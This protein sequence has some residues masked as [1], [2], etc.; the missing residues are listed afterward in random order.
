M[1]EFTLSDNG[2]TARVEI[3]GGTCLLEVLSLQDAAYAVLP[4]EK[5]RF[6]SRQGM[7]YY[8]NL[9][10]RQGGVV[11]GVRVDGTLRASMAVLGPVDL[12][13]AIALRMITKSPVPFHHAALTDNVIVFKG[14]T[15][16]P[17]FRGNDL[18]QVMLSY[19]L[20]LPLVQVAHHV[21]AQIS[22][23]DK[24]RWDALSRQ[25]FGIVSASYD[26]EN[27]EPRF[28][29]QKPA[30]GFDFSPEPI[31]DEVDHMDDFSAIINLT[32]REALVGMYDGTSTHKLVFMRDREV[33][34]L[35]PMMA[36]AQQ[37][38]R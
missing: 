9:L 17:D 32:Q 13:E 1:K 19:A 20:D 6:M 24:R 26:P 23:G 7:A 5:R 8:Q 3:L 12:R 33:L 38:L 28:V 10:T 37:S 35:M 34:N 31:V 27:G 21:F 36:K 16:H 25:K 30:F 14:M 2:G 22:S 11:V 15:V 29:F 4:S 18:N